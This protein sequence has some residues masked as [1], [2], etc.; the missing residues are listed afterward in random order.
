[1]TNRKQVR[2]ALEK[3]YG[4]RTADVVMAAMSGRKKSL[5]DCRADYG[6]TTVAA[7]LAN[8]TRGTYDECIDNPTAVTTRRF[9]SFDF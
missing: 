4:E 9:P 3:K 2:R 5:N 6:I 8:Y 1:M 7:V